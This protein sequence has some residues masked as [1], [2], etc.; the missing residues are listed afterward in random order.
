MLHRQRH[1]RGQAEP[2]AVPGQTGP[3]PGRGRGAGTAPAGA[4]GLQMG[5]LPHGGAHTSQA[6]SALGGGC[7][8]AHRTEPAQGD[9]GLSVRG[10]VADIGP[11][12]SVGRPTTR[13]SALEGNRLSGEPLDGSHCRIPLEQRHEWGKCDA[14]PAAAD[15]NRLEEIGCRS[16]KRSLQS[17]LANRWVPYT[18]GQTPSSTDPGCNNH[19]LSPHR[20]R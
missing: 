3:R 18:P 11:R 12:D 4:R 2:G 5:D 1:R 17:R 6:H 15:S 20:S 7:R 8:L 9:R 14:I 13:P 16:R 19:G 10:G